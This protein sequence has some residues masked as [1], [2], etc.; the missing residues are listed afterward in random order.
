[1]KLTYYGYAPYESEYLEHHGIL[2]QKWGIRRY[3]NEDGSYTEKGL[4]RR[5]KLYEKIEKSY[6]KATKGSKNILTSDYASDF[7]KERAKQNIQK[8]D[9][10][11]SLRKSEVDTTMN[12]AENRI[13]GSAIIG[14][15]IAGPW[16]AVVGST[17]S[18]VKNRASWEERA[19]LET[20]YGDIK[21]RNI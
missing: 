16:G 19:A 21:I 1:M 13:K 15:L 14:G 8:Q 3:Q 12:Y 17:I 10:L 4:K 7:S 5:A 20:T 6:E 9:A 2:G 18:G 11:R